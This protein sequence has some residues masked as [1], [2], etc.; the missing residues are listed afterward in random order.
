MSDGAP[1]AATVDP[2]AVQGGAVQARVVAGAVALA[3]PVAAVALALLLAASLLWL[4]DIP[5]L[6]AYRALL[7]GA[8]GTDVNLGISLARATPLILVGLGV[9]FAMRANFINVGGEGQLYFGALAGTWAALHLS[10]LSGTLS[11][12]LA[13]LT[14]MAAGAAWA[15]VPGLLKAFRGSNEVITTILLNY[16][17]VG[18]V[19]YFVYGPFKDPESEQFPQSAAVPP[20]AQLPRFDIG[21]P[22]HLGF[23]LAL[24]AAVVLAVLL[25]RTAIGYEMKV[26]SSSP[27][28]AQYAAIPVRRRLLLSVCVAGGLAGLGGAVEILGVQVRLVP[29]FM[30]GVA[31]TAIVV[32]LL[33]QNK[34]LGVVLAGLFIGGLFN[35]AESMQRA[36]TTPSVIVYAVEALVV[37]FLLVGMNLRAGRRAWRRSLLSSLRGSRPADRSDIAA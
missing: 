29:D 31:F 37:I 4:A 24:A 5:P 36:T 21:A 16:V 12:T 14:S 26:I 18:I 3:T 34:P 23:W 11:V 10:S 6:E 8:V 9:A 7:R 22:V 2:P 19:S 13:L 27:R 25:A 15:L 1:L 35:G 20:S 33:G 30:P 28:A 32:A 17:A